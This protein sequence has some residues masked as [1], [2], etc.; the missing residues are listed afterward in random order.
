MHADTIVAL[1]SAGLAT[2][3]AIWVPWV[4]FRLALR[5]DQARWLREQRAQLYVDLL[6]EAHAEKEHLEYTLADD[7]T[8]ESM[9]RYY[10]ISGCHPWSAPGSAPVEPSSPARP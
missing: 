8:R 5:Q 6:T 10:T 3:I 9:R 4:A 2:I 7:D 1:V